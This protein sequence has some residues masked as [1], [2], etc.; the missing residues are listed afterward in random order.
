MKAISISVHENVFIYLCHV[1]TNMS[2]FEHKIH[3]IIVTIRTTSWVFSPLGA[4][5]T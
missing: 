1:K 3:V 4:C 5:R 2:H